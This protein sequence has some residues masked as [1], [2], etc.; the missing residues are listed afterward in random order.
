MVQLPRIDSFG[1]N[2]KKLGLL[3]LQGP[4]FVVRKRLLRGKNASNKT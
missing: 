4:T 3:T 1:K 2:L